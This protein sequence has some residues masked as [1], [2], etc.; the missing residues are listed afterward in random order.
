[1]WKYNWVITTY[2]ETSWPL[3][4]AV[5]IAGVAGSNPAGDMDVC[6]VWMLSCKGLCVGLITRPEESY[7]WGVSKCDCEASI[8]RRPWP[9]RSCC[10]GGHYEHCVFYLTHNSGRVRQ[11]CV[12]TRWNSVH[13]QVLLSATPQGGMFPEV[14]HPQALLASLVFPENFSSQK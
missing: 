5:R 6:L 9:T 7:Q 3:P 2:I 4:V 11:I 12:L 14:S 1:M 13:L 10:A 8:M